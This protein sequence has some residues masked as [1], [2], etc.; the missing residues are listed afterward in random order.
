MNGNNIKT[1]ALSFEI[2]ATH[3]EIITFFVIAWKQSIIDYFQF[4]SLHN[5]R[6]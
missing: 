4:S 2:R 1:L 3:V 6:C 5:I